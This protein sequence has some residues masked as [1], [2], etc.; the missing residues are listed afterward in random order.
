MPRWTRWAALVWLAAAGQGVFF[1]DSLRHP[2]LTPLNTL[3]F[4][5][6]AGASLGAL[7]YRYRRRADPSQRQQIKWV[8]FGVAAGLGGMLGIAM[9]SLLFP[10]LGSPGSH[11][12]RGSLTHACSR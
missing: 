10:A 8:V 12:A 2:W 4:I 9:L 6:G 5:G 11:P 1:P 7:V 3:A